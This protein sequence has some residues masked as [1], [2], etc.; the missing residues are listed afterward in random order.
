MSR[1]IAVRA[2]LPVYGEWFAFGVF[3]GFFA[4]FASY[5]FG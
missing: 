3:A 1:I 5:L 4:S 2:A